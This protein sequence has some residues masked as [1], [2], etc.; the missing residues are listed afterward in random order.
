MDADIQANL[1]SLLKSLVENRPAKSVIQKYIKEVSI[2]GGGGGVSA[3]STPA[4]ILP[5]KHLIPDLAKKD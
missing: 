4:V 5:R 2:S 3:G 1:S